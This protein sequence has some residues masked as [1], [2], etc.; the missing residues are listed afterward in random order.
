MQV[1]QGLIGV[2][3]VPLGFMGL[4]CAT[5]THRGSQGPEGSNR[6]RSQGSHRGSWACKAQKGFT[7]S[8]GV[9]QDPTGSN[10]GLKCPLAALR[11]SQGLATGPQR[12][13]ETHRCTQGLPGAHRELQDP[14]GVHK[15]F[16]GH[17]GVH[18]DYQGLTRAYR[19]S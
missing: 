1:P 17:V 7:G 2:C 15:G 11:G 18:R 12:L 19:G 10:R 8:C 5:G 4:K 6:A 9:P 13:I 14:A 3:R 16:Q